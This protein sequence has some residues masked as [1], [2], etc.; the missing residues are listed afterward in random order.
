MLTYW[1][2]FLVPAWASV[3][4]PGKPRPGSKNLELSWL[5]VGL[6]LA[7]LIGL[8]HQV[9]GDW[10]T[11]ESH[12]QYMLGTSLSQVWLMGD[13]GYYLV[14]WLST[15]VDGGVYLVNT[16][17]GTLFSLGLVAFC[18]R[19]P[20]PWLALAV[21]VPYMV[22]VVA[23][24]YSRQG[25]ALGLALLGIVGLSKGSNLRFV[26]CVALAATFHKSAVLLIPLAVLATPRG[27]LWT[28]IWVGITGAILYS[29]LLAE[30]VDNL[31]TNYI[32]A[33]YQSEG[34]AVRI[35]M[36]ALPAVLLLWLRKRFVWPPAERNLWTFMAFLAI[37][38]VGWLLVSSSSTA[39]D[40]LALYLIP[41]QLYV[42]ARLPDLLGRNA[43]RRNLVWAVVGYYTVVMF[44]WLNFA[45][46]AG[47]WLPYRSWLLE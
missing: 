9:G 12:Y 33:G 22:T 41:L 6:V 26:I 17:V 24:G 14:N 46:H 4:V 5:A 10:A 13:P 32:D 2:M 25:V 23:M 45:S 29:V 47:Y 27:R 21:A 28:A 42:F 20:R 7:L 8:R 3:S 11:Y 39:V 37:A 36:N 18:R 35:A 40:R 30:S 15:Q 38:C 44:V 19:Q 1:L 43:S 31:V 16:V 34:A